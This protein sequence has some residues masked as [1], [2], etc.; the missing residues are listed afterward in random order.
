L[1]QFGTAGYAKKGQTAFS[2]GEPMAIQPVIRPRKYLSLF[3]RVSGELQLQRSEGSRRRKR[4]AR[5]ALHCLAVDHTK[6]TFKFQGRNYRLTD[7][8]GR[9]VRELPA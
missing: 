3:F 9:V 4:S 6:L 2:A 8:H 7:V 5:H 1:A